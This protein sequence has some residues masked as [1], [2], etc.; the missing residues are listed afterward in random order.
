ML[1]WLL[2]IQRI[3][4]ENV[5]IATPNETHNKGS[6]NVIVILKG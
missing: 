4:L 5:L 3:D 6:I 1:H 2:G